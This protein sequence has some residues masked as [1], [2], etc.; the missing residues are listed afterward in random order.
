[1]YS[2][3][4]GAT[5]RMSYAQYRDVLKEDAIDNH[6][7]RVRTEPDGFPGVSAVTFFR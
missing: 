6:F 2:D 7:I 3:V 4:V 1:M 5:D